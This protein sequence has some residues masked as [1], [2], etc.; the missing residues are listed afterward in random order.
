MDSG[1]RY[2]IHLSQSQINPK[3]SAK[4]HSFSSNS[5][6]RQTMSS[7]TKA[8][9]LYSLTLDK[10]LL[11]VFCSL[12]RCECCLIALV[13][14]YPPSAGQHAPQR[15]DCFT[16]TLVLLRYIENIEIFDI[17]VSNF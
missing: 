5:I 12:P 17:S 4:S 13:P 6:H 1:S 15:I 3:I 7:Q 11:N 16:S 2:L 10:K 8:S 9:I 14:L